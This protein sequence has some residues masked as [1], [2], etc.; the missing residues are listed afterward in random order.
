MISMALPDIHSLDAV[1]TVPS[2]MAWG[3][4]TGIKSRVDGFGDPDFAPIDPRLFR[5]LVIRNNVVRIMD[6][7]PE[8][9][10]LNTG[11]SVSYCEN[12][13]IEDNVID[14]PKAN[15]IVAANCTNLRFFN[16]RTPAGQLI[17]GVVGTTKQDELTT[18]I[19]DAAVLAIL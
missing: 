11:I 7:L 16:N 4:P 9:L 14:L 6:G 8:P 17:Q 10:A 13:L 19:E 15:P 5:Q 1:R 2:D 3:T 18:F 12:A